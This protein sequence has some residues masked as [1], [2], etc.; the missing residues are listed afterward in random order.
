MCFIPQR[1][2]PDH[3]LLAVLHCDSRSLNRVVLKLYALSALSHSPKLSFLSELPVYVEGEIECTYHVAATPVVGDQHHSCGVVVLGGTDIIR[4]AIRSSSKRPL[5]VLD[6]QST[7]LAW[8]FSNIAACVF[9]LI[10]A[11]HITHADSSVSLVLMK[12]I[13]G[14]SSGTNSG[15][16]LC[17]RLITTQHSN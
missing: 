13:R 2:H 8:P 3:L 1:S 15:V 9:G 10:C 11:M 5:F 16:S 4:I 14:S 6:E 12:T 17:L 7:H